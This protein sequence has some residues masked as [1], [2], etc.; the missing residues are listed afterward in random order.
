MTASTPP[1]VRSSPGTHVVGIPP[2]PAQITTAPCSSS[3]RI[4]RISKIR[5]G[6]GDGT[7]RRRWSPSRLNTQPFSAASASAVGVVVDRPDELGRIG[8]RRVVGVDLDHRQDRGERHLGRAAGCRAPARSGSRSSP[9][10]G[11]RARRA[12]RPRRPCTRPPA[13]RADRPADRCRG[14]ARAG[15]AR[16]PERARGRRCG[17]WPA[18]TSAVIGSPRLSRALP[19]RATRTRTADL[20]S[21][22]SRRAAP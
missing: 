12:D 1:S 18:A 15:A 9:R 11:R 22:A 19:P 3:H 10:S 4:G 8:E 13:A 2:P 7:T 21:R 14:T 16:P 17:C 6:A 5:F 20:S